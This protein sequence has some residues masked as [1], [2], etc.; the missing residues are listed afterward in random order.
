M[1]FTIIAQA[2]IL[3]H[4]CLQILFLK[5]IKYSWQRALESFLLLR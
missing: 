1:A 3:N 4:I 2:M 5:T